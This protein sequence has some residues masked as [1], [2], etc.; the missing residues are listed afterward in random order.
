MAVSRSRSRSQ[1]RTTTTPTPTTAMTSLSFFLNYSAFWI[2]SFGLVVVTK[3]Y[4]SWGD[5]GY[6]LIG[7][8]VAVPAWLM[9]VLSPGSKKAEL[10]RA[11]SVN[12][13]IAILS[14]IGNHF[15]THYFFRVLGARYSFP[16]TWA[17]NEVP[18]CMY[19]LTHGY[20][21]TYHVVAG[22]ALDRVQ[23][24]LGKRYVFVAS[25]V[26][27]YLA[28]VTEAV[29]I[30]SVPYYSFHDERAFLV[31]GSAFYA[32]MLGISF[33]WYHT[34]LGSGWT[35]AQAAKEAMAASMVIFLALDIW[36]L[37]IGPI[38]KGAPTG[39]IIPN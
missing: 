32:I 24:R 35:A 6:T 14:Y 39:A 19:L 7:V 9:P 36:R 28:A 33:H 1:K 38:Y 37:T 27:G 5:I 29:T 22:E 31:Y 15:W 16:L 10:A 34:S 21:L 3:W 12:I 26:F 20:F 30:S 13:Y 23:S 25:L 4:E 8:W 17:V 18:I 11:L 2:L